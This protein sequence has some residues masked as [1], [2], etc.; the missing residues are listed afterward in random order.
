[1]IASVVATLAPGRPLQG[2]VNEIASSTQVETGAVNG[3]RLPLTI[4]ADDNRTIED[5]TRWI[6]D[7]DGV[8]FVDVVFVHFEPALQDKPDE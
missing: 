5:I 4:E 6:Q 2:V 8:L 7:R 3:Q 1:M